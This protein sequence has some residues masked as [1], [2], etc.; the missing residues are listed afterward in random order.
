MNELKKLKEKQVDADENSVEYK[1]RHKKIREIE[2][3]KKEMIANHTV[4]KK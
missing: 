1:M 2:R 4:I 3:A